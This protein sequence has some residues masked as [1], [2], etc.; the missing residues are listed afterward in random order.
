MEK[1]FLLGFLVCLILSSCESRT[2]MRTV[3]ISQAD[4]ESLFTLDIGMLE[5]QIAI[6][7]FEGHR[8]GRRPVDIA[9]RNGLFYISNS[10]GAKI[11][12]Y[13]SYGD[14]LFM[15]YNE[16]F[17]PPPLTLRPLVEGTLVTRWAVSYPLLEP[18]WVCVD[19]RS[20]I[21]VQDRLPQELQSF[22]SP[23]MA[24]LDNVVLHFDADGRFLRHLGREG[25]GGTPFPMIEGL[26][27][28]NQDELAVI[29]RLSGGWEIYWY[30]PEGLL[31]F[32]VRL[33]LDALPIPPGGDDIFPSLDR[34]SVGPNGRKLYVK[35][36]YYHYTYDDSTNTRT[37]IE[38]STSVVWIMDAQ[39]GIWDNHVAVPFFEYMFMD[40][41][42]RV[43]NS[44][45][46]S[47]LGITQNERIFL[48]FP[49]EGGYSIF[50]VSAA[51]DSFGD[52]HQSFIQVANEELQFNAFD[53]S[54]DGILSG[55][56]VD[57]YQVRL[58]WWR[59]D[60][61]IQESFD[62]R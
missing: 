2:L 46:Y 52:Q 21:Y 32:M 14:L 35:I 3:Q 43:V 56:L 17:N 15:I 9:M 61:L 27:A 38:P 41:N 26:Y 37:G 16:D 55:L 50:I 47:L 1:K 7:D 22:D 57:E 44:M 33:N 42:R 34:I 60:L 24:L 45:P 12:R 39:E 62:E 25:I 59:T 20:H 5:D 19:S 49:A 11:L 58:I 36:D 23:N 10:N 40:Q 51:E 8:G 29:C 48:Y 4:R 18:G 13:N 6:Y 54:A 53:L 28:T 31:L 30:D